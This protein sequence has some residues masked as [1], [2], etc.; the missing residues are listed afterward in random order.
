LANKAPSAPQPRK[1]KD[2][3]TVTTNPPDV[4]VINSIDPDN[5]PVT[6]AIEIDTVKTFDSP[7]KIAQDKIAQDPSGITTWKPTAPLKEN[8]AYFWRTRASDGKTTTPWVF[9]GE[10]FVNS[11]ND[12][13]TAPTLQAPAKG[14]TLPSTQTTLRA[15]ESTDPDKDKLTYHLQVSTQQD[16]SSEVIE[17]NQLNPTNNAVSWQP[18]G[19]EAG[20]TY[21]WRARAHD[22]KEHGP[23]S[24]V[25]SFNIQAANP[26]ETPQEGT[27]AES[28][29]DGA[30]NEQ[31]AESN[32]DGGNNEQNTESNNDGNT[33]DGDTKDTGQGNDN[34]PDTKTPGGGCG[35]QHT[36]PSSPALL[37][38]LF[39]LLA[40]RRRTSLAAKYN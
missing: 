18:A 35:C 19:L 3:D 39:L 9:G 34:N 15:S 29:N 12:L 5:E 1:P 37:L 38:F 33:N 8:T 40:L 25:W 13:P 23:W 2:G 26:S 36:S 16:F 27:N 22:G 7:D 14:D 20:K 17:N 30:N 6:L 31:N 10:F 32:N 28:T 4:E 11:Q 21:H 24:E